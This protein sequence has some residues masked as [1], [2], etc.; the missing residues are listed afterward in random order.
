M[1]KHLRRFLVLAVG[2]SLIM[3]SATFAADTKT[4]STQNSTKVEAQMEYDDNWDDFEGEWDEFD[5]DFEGEEFS[6]PETGEEAVKELKEYYDLTAKEEA[7]LVKL[8]DELLKFEEGLDF[9]KMTDEEWEALDKK[10]EDLWK[11]IDEV[12]VE[13][14]KA[15][16]LKE[17]IPGLDQFIEEHDVDKSKLSADELDKIQ[18]FHKSIVAAQ[19]SGNADKLYD[20]Y[21]SMYVWADENLSDGV[22]IEFDDAN[23]DE[24]F[25]G[26][27][28]D[29][30]EMTDEEHKALMAEYFAEELPTLDA[31]IEEHDVDKSKLSSDELNKIEDFYKD[32]KA[33]HKDKNEDKLINAYDALYAW[34]DEFLSDDVFVEFDDADFDEEFDGD[35]DEFEEMTDEEYQKMVVE[36]IKEFDVDEFLKEWPVDFSKDDVKEMKSIQKDMLKAAEEGNMDEVEKQFDAFE[37]VLEKYYE[38]MDKHLEENN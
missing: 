35:Y 32:I 20:E 19:K 26:D 23:Y 34:A 21:E 18:N 1:N 12:L 27:Y 30:E 15:E 5:D 25:D 9:D 13:Y 17:D 29:F 2:C 3:G 33:A 8:Y 10:T 14:D 31:F 6:F 36:E 22:F 11:Q 38:E 24:E 16:L 37:K 4:G 7:K 28:D